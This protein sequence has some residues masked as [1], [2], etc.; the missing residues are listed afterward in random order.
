MICFSY[1][2]NQQKPFFQVLIHGLIRD[3]T[4]RKMSKSLGN[5]I[6]PTDLIKQYGADATRLTFVVSQ[7]QDQDIRLQEN[8][9]KG[10]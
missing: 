2:F 10:N 9:L 3:T 4:G 6:D 8:K 1:Y 7:A 5:V